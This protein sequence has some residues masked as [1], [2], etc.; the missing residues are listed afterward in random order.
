MTKEKK[1]NVI[2]KADSCKVDSL[3]ES[4]REAEIGE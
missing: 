4:Y 1:M 2:V 3:T